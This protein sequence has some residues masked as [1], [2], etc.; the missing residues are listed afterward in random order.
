LLDAG[1]CQGRDGNDCAATARVIDE[2]RQ[3]FSWDDERHPDYLE[4]LPT[5]DLMGMNA[6]QQKAKSLTDGLSSPLY[7]QNLVAYISPPNPGEL[8][9]PA[10]Y[11]WATLGDNSR[12]TAS[13]GPGFRK[14]VWTISTWLM[15]PDNA[16][17][18][19]ADR[20][21][22][23]LIDAVIESWVTAVMPIPMTDPDTGRVSQLVA[24]GEKFTVNQLPVHMLAN[25]QLYLYEALIEFQIEESSTP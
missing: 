17:N 3:S 6:V 8:T 7:K 16:T 11:I 13:R 15:S 4:A 24:I 5:G 25:Q 22:A 20:A 21:F 19:N 9:G 10:A 1:T 18:P 14:T 2:L 12:R 23:C